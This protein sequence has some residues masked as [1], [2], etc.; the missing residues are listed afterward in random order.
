M[1]GAPMAGMPM[2]GSP[3]PPNGKNPS[4]SATAAAKPGAG[5][6][7]LL[8][9]LIV[10]L[11]LLIAAGLAGFF[12][13]R[14]ELWGGKMLPDPAAIA[15]TAGDANAKGGK[16]GK[17][18][19]VKARDVTEALKAKGLNT[20]TASEFS[21][22]AKGSFLG[23]KGAKQGE[24]I[25]AGSTVT[26]RESAGPGVPKG[27][28]GKQ[29]DK[30]VDTFKAMNVPV[31]YKQIIIAP[32]STTP[33]GQV[34]NTSPAPGTAL[35]DKDKDTGIYIGVT[36]KGD[37]IPADIL[38]ADKDKTASQLESQGYQVELKAHYSSERYVGK[39]S[40]SYPAPG[41][42]P[43]KGQT[44][45]LYYGVDKTSNMDLL[46]KDDNS[47]GFT[48]LN[49]NT[50]P[51]IGLYCKSEVK[52]T[53][54]DCITLEEADG[55][56]HQGKGGHLQI[57]GHE[58]ADPYDDLWFNNFSQDASALALEPS[59]F[60][61]ADEL[62]MRNHLL[63]KDWGMFELYAGMD[64]PNCGSNVMT[65]S[66]EHCA[67]GTY[68][69][70]TAGTNASRNTGMTYEMK[71][72][73]VYFPAGS[74][75]KSLED[76][77]YFDADS[78][79]VAKKQ[80]AADT[81]R[82]FILVRDKTQYDTT[83]VPVTNWGKQSD[84]FVPTNNIMNGYKNEMVPMKPAPSDSTVYYLAE[85]NGDLDWGSLPD[86]KVTGAGDS[87]DKT[88]D[89]NSKDTAN[90]DSKK[91]NA[92]LTEAMRSAA[93]DYTFSSGSGG[94]WTSLTIKDDGTF[95]GKYS[96]ADLGG[97]G[98]S[99]PNG[100]LSES[101]FSG[102]FSSATKNGDGTYA[103]QCDANAFAVTNGNV[104]DVRIENGT[105]IIVKD[106]YGMTPCDK[107]TLYPKGYDTTQF[108]DGMRMW[109]GG[110][111]F[112]QYGNTLPGPALYNASSTEDEQFTFYNGLG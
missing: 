97:T 32:D 36:T 96:D 104:G 31:H 110:R 59:S 71:D 8:I 7:R 91:A 29:A 98:D 99:Y 103:L 95:S 61:S 80:K 37:G 49:S 54:T 83:S 94:W 100:T 68:S 45:T 27:T 39:I 48:V 12:T 81:T 109:T 50:T 88:G 78:L 56:F 40:G 38:G 87:A 85:Q 89:S 13:Y 28:I 107:F 111:S 9:V 23:Y 76:S 74:D 102:R 105:Q 24:R 64:L 15:T 1:P 10:V 14:A 2:P 26:V 108:G 43:D 35:A 57:K 42:T 72:F 52:D 47:F 33:E 22:Q 73:I 34:A 63:L 86:A 18:S 46:S 20:R 62:V 93:G 17:K 66:F 60:Q 4:G 84:P 41:T 65:G 44:I 75:L 30:V 90:K 82:P 77:G 51:M 67:N 16:D 19:P 69:K 6:R 11:V 70:A 53:D 92:A 79:T 3:T 106:A 25:A 21:G 5:K 101:V 58:P 112:D 55:P